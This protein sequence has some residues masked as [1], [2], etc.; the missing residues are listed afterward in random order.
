MT[1][2]PDAMDLWEE[3]GGGTP[4]FDP[5]RWHAL[6]RERILGDGSEFPDPAEPGS[7]RI[8]DRTGIIE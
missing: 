6:I 2:R 1:D 8:G 7:A 4:G 5:D 3:A